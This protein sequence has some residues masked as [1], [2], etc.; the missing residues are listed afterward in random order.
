MQRIRW[1]KVS[2]WA[3]TVRRTVYLLGWNNDFL[4]YGF[5]GKY[6]DRIRLQDTVNCILSQNYYLMDADRIWG[7]NKMKLSPETPSVFYMDRNTMSLTGIATW[8]SA[9]LPMDEVLSVSNLL[10]AMLLME[11]T[12]QWQ[13]LLVTGNIIRQSIALRYGNLRMPSE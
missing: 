1:G 12:W 3:D 4:L 9:L 5:D 7:H 13:N 10:G 11:V 6:K 8:N 2:F